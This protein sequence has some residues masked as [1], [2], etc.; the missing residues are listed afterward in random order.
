MDADSEVSGELHD[1]AADNW[2]PLL[3]IADLAGGDWPAKARA[4]ALALS[5]E[6]AAEDGSLGVQLLQDIREA[7]ATLDGAEGI[8][9]R[10]LLDFLTFSLPDSPWATYG[11]GRGLTANSLARLLRPFGIKP[12]QFRPP[13]GDPIRGYRVRDFEDPFRRYLTPG[14]PVQAVQPPSDKG[15]S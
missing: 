12:K 14:D 7:F 9:T 6:E 10:E 4:A 8:S 13:G 5:G 1:R 11:R 2:R 3:A 15:F